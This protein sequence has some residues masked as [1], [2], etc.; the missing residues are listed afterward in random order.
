MKIILEFDSE[1]DSKEFF[2]YFKAS[3][4]IAFYEE[5]LK[6]LDSSSKNQTVKTIKDKV[7]QLIRDLDIEE[8]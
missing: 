8:L 2:V 1:K 6:F 5:F 4:I 3:Q 7:N